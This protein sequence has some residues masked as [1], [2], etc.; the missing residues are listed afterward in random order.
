[1]KRIG[2]IAAAAVL[3]G[4]SVCAKDISGTVLDS[5]SG[6]K[7]G[8][9]NVKLLNHNVWTICDSVG[10]FKL[11]VPEEALTDTL[12]VKYLGYEEVQVLPQKLQ[13][14]SR[15]LAVMLKR[16]P[17]KLSEVAV[18]PVATKS[19]KV[20]KKKPGGMVTADLGF[21]DP[22]MGE[23]YGFEFKN[24]GKRTWLK[25]FG[26]Y[27]KQDNI[28][29]KVLSSMKFRVNVYDMKDIDK[30][31]ATDLENVLPEPIYVDYSKNDIKGD[32]WEYKLAD[33]ILLPDHALVE[34]E[35][36][37]NAKSEGEAIFFRTNL[38][39]KS[40]WYTYRSKKNG[41]QYWDKC[42]FASPFFM[43]CVR[44]K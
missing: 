28:Y 14:V 27:I 18:V 38:F 33:A 1:M 35:F 30:T 39:G 21:R 11:D 13:E 20:G 9:A 31:P 26:F 37:E 2:L 3:C 5:E 44:E 24:K 8:Y 16:Q 10:G 19:F 23:S 12:S 25:S 41:K 7:L 15:P 40:S 32:T 17:K 6:E 36:V 22:L 43:E 29:G 34:I 4:A 42:P